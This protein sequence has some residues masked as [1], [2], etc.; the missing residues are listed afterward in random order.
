MSKKAWGRPEGGG[1]GLESPNMCFRSR[2]QHDI[3]RRVAEGPSPA[4][5]GL[6]FVLPCLEFSILGTAWE[7]GL[8]F[9]AALIFN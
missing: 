8:L 1:N 3:I 4:E 5:A 9:L 7:P 2:C 6:G